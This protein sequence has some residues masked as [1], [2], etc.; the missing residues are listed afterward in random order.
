MLALPSSSST[1]TIATATPG[2]IPQIKTK[3]CFILRTASL[4]P[5]CDEINLGKISTDYLVNDD[6]AFVLLLSTEDVW[7]I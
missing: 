1:I 5:L 2:E 4:A 3:A 7:N 6:T